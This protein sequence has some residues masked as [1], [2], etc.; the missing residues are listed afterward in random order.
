MGGAAIHY[1]RQLQ[2]KSFTV[3]LWMLDSFTW[4]KY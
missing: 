3:G 2:N 4:K 1:D